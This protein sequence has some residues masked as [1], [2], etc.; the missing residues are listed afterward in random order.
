[1]K[2]KANQIYLKQVKEIQDVMSIR[3]QKF[4]LQKIIL[5]TT[6]LGGFNVLSPCSYMVHN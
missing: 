2:F 6:I 5:L 1:M 4:K 3:Y